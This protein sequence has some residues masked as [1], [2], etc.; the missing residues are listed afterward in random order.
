MNEKVEGW[1]SIKVK[2]VINVKIRL[3][4]K[5]NKGYFGLM[6]LDVEEFDVNKEF[7]ENYC[8]W[9]IVNSEYEKEW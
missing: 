8:V 2:S 7:K 1:D 9:G 3:W 6:F 5:Y 4:K